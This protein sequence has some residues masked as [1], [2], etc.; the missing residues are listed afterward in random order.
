MNE[1]DSERIAS[2]LEGDGLVPT[3]E[4]EEAD[5]VVFNTCC[6]RENADNK[7]YGN[8]GQIKAQRD[9][10][11]DLKI[12]VSG[13]LAQKDR[14]IIQKKAPWVDVVFGTNNVSRAADLLR[15][16]TE[17]GPI[18]EIFDEIANDEVEFASALNAVRATDYQSWLTIQMGCDNNC[19]FCI[20]PSVRG[21]EVSRSFAHIISEVEQLAA[22]G[23]TELTLL[24]QNVN[25]YGRDITLSLRRDPELS[26]EIAGPYWADDRR[27]RPLFADLLRQ[28]GAVEGISR[29][30]FTSPHPKDLR[31]ETVLAMAE[32]S[33]VCEH[34]HFPLQSGSNRVLSLMHRG[35]SAERYLEK[36]SMAR[37]SIDDLAVTTDIIVGFPGETDEDFEETLQVAA[38]AEYDSAYTFIFSPRPGT[39]ASEMSDLFISSDVI[40]ERF[41]RLKIV[42]E[43]SALLK[44]QQRIGKVEEVLVD[45]PSKKNPL[46][47]SGRTRQNKLVHMT[48]PETFN[49]K[50]PVFGVG[51]YVGVAIKSAAVYFLRGDLV[52][53]LAAPKHKRKLQLTVG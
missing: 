20:V 40:A 35:Y 30:R 33:A 14:E 32:T 41:E 12:M 25:S 11:P 21:K 44:H 23:V 51:S 3:L 26:A 38:A 50:D 17:S 4:Q 2:V 37:A 49:P 29:I 46:I 22:Q 52:E 1:H 15:E 7:L 18:I 10:N 9:R 31:P 28:A 43:R 8:L 5:V 45:G 6:I 24:G 39:E 27:A 48:L 53:V 19:A 13:C 16:S 47:W 42:V 36:L 34:L